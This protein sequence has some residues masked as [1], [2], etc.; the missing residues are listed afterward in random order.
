MLACSSE[1]QNVFFKSETLASIDTNV[2]SFSSS[3]LSKTLIEA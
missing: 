1:G 2:K 3:L